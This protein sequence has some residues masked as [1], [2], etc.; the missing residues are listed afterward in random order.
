MIDDITAACST[1]VAEHRAHGALCVG[2][3]EPNDDAEGYWLWA[4]C[5]CGAVWERW[6]GLEDGIA[7]LG[8]PELAR[9][10]KE[11]EGESATNSER[12]R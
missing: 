8:P 4:A 3:D 11:A 5:P 6:A 12:G 9:W 1:F 7:D 10:L 2:G